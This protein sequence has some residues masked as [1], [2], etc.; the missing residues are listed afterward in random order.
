MTVPCCAVVLAAG[1]KVEISNG[2]HKT[3]PQPRGSQCAVP[4]LAFFLR[5]T[6][7]FKVG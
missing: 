3:F 6:D 7:W 1:V 4:R 5:R 2:V